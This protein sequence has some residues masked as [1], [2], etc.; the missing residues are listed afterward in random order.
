MGLIKRHDWDWTGADAEFK[1]ALELN[2]NSFRSRQ[3][4]A[5]SLRVR[6]RFDE[7]LAEAKKA[8]D[9]DPLS[10]PMNRF[11]G[12]V[13]LFRQEYD[14]AIEE[15]QKT[16]EMDPSDGTTHLWL[17][18][19]YWGKGEH[20]KAI[21]QAEKGA[22]LSNLNPQRA[23]FLRHVL[24]GN[25]AEAVRTIENWG[26]RLQPQIKAAY[27]VLLGDKD[28]AIELLENGLDEGYSSVA[29]MNSWPSFAPLRDDPRFQDLL[30]RMNL[31]P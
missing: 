22:S 30:R 3:T 26:S 19:A 11:I 6:R 18:T 29:Q 16:L 20:E 15:L 27:Y 23:V 28:R 17:S 4:Y 10:V 14:E 5:I 31:E 13:Y 2:P 24:S 1:R 25:R 9:L 7:A 12:E 8:L 21:A